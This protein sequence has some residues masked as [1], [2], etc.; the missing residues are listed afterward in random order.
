MENLNV[1]NSTCNHKKVGTTFKTRLATCVSL[2][3]EGRPQVMQVVVARQSAQK[4][5]KVNNYL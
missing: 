5:A 2:M 1:A 3:N 4:C